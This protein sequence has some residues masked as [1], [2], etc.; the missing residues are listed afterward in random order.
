[1]DAARELTLRRS[2]VPATRSDRSDA[3]LRRVSRLGQRHDLGEELPRLAFEQAVAGPG[4]N[5]SLLSTTKRKDGTLEAV[6]NGHPLYYFS[7]DKKS[8]DVTGQGR[9]GVACRFAG[10][11]QD[12]HRFIA[13][14]WW[15]LTS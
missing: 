7:G 13:E 2:A 9:R 14:R 5:A 15:L 3:A 12:R 1:M 10:R 8:G 4:V 11:R 6:Y